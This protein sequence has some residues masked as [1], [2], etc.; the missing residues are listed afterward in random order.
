LIGDYFI[1]S[2]PDCQSRARATTVRMH[3]GRARL[4]LDLLT[5]GE[6]LRGAR[7]DGV[8]RTIAQELEA[9]ALGMGT[10]R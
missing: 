9:V 4:L 7:L 5:N 2:I 8:L 6:Q 10:A 3:L 1:V